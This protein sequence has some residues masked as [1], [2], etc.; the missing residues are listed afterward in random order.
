MA[1]REE[2]M[3][4]GCAAA[5]KILLWKGFPKGL[6]DD[7][8]L[9]A[10]DADGPQTAGAGGEAEGWFQPGTAGFVLKMMGCPNPED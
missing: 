6:V 2:S 8:V 3:E 7:H 4:A 1:R 9:G 10:T 5:G